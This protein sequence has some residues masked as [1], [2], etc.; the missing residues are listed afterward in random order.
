MGLP[1]EKHR[2]CSLC[3]GSSYPWWSS[4]KTS[5]YICINQTV[6]LHIATPLK[7]SFF[8][9]SARCRSGEVALFINYQQTLPCTSIGKDCGN[10]VILYMV[11]PSQHIQT[12]SDAFAAVDFKKYCGKRRNLTFLYTDAPYIFEKFQKSSVA[13]LLYVGNGN[14]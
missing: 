14:L 12:R 2:Y 11:D 8:F 7:N 9:P 3:Q 4:S 6:N 13:K 1:C 10:I 5:T